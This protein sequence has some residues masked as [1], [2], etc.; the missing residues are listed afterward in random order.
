M[1]RKHKE[2]KEQKTTTKK[3][4]RGN[5]GRE[6]PTVFSNTGTVYSLTKVRWLEKHK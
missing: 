5:W 4:N 3:K 1:Q 2:K 6:G